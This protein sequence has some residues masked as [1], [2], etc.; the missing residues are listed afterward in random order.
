MSSWSIQQIHSYL[1]IT[2][3]SIHKAEKME[4]GSPVYELINM[5]KQIRIFGTWLNQISEIHAH[6]PLYWFLFD[7][8]YISQPGRVLNLLNE[9]HLQKLFDVILYRF[10]LLLAILSLCL[11]HLLDGWMST[12]FHANRSM[13]LFNIPMIS[14]SSSRGKLKPI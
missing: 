8:D 7:H 6:F 4:I 11:G 13:F 1:I 5:R 14:A 2:R 3:V 10:Y 9:T 12:G